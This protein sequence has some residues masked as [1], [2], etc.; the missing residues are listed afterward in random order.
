MISRITVLSA[1]YFFK[2]YFVDYHVKST[3]FY[4]V[5]QITS[6]SI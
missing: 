2:G 4:I 1:P 6:D 5:H 3:E